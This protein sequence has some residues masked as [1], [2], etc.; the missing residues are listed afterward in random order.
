MRKIRSG[1]LWVIVIAALPVLR[2]LQLHGLAD[3]NTTY[4]IFSALGE[5]A[6]LVAL[7]LYAM[8]FM[9]STRLRVFERLFGG[10][11]K[12]YNA[13]HIIGGLALIFMLAHPLLLAM[14][15]APDAMKD[16]A[17]F[18][19]PT[20]GPAPD[21]P[22][23]FGIMTL[24]VTVTLLIITFYANWKHET[25]LATHRWIGLGLLLA[26]LH[27]YLIPSDTAVDGLLRCYMLTLIGIGLLAYTYRTLLGQILVRRKH[28]AVKAVEPLTDQALR[29]RLAPRDPK[30]ALAFR[31]GQ[32]VFIRFLQ[33]G[34]ANQF[35]PF[36]ITVRPGSPEINLIVKTLGDFT[37]SLRQLQPGTLAEIEGAFGSFSS[38][39]RGPQIW[40]AGGIG[41]TPFLSMAKSLG[42]NARVELFY[43]VDTDNDLVEY[44]ELLAIA[45]RIPESLHLTIYLTKQMRGRITAEYINQ[46]SSGGIGQKHVLLCGPQSMMDGM[47]RQL[48]QLGI[49]KDHIHTEEFA[50]S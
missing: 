18:L 25:W 12:A 38:Q 14:R 49:A 46:H 37:T 4:G 6:G 22:K 7:S 10:L 50:L 17:M 40:I 8:N 15:Y 1:W 13:H 47:G 31:P 30:E 27:V 9:L 35:H 44:Q 32:F 11:N 16:A 20:L 21:W 26:G 43:V 45:A 48:R 39:A 36:S 19:L 2:R 34:I 33:P 3:M 28:M 5:S 41:I 42:P 23:N 24:T 29:I